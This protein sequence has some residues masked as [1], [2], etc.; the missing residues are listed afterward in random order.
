MNEKDKKQEFVDKITTLRLLYNLRANMQK[1][2]LGQTNPQ[3]CRALI[4]G[5]SLFCQDENLSAKI[6]T[7]IASY[8]ETAPFNPN[9]FKTTTVK[10]DKKQQQNVKKS[11]AQ[12]KAVAL[13]QKQI[14][15]ELAFQHSL[16]KMTDVPENA[17]FESISA[18]DTSFEV[19]IAGRD[20]PLVFNVKIYKG[21]HITALGFRAL[22]DAK[23][24]K[25][26]FDEKTFKLLQSL[27]EKGLKLEKAVE[28]ENLAKKYAPSQYKL[29]LGLKAQDELSAEQKH[30]LEI[31]NKLAATD[32][33]RFILAVKKRKLEASKHQDFFDALAKETDLLK[34][35]TDREKLSALFV[36]NGLND[37]A[38]K[39]QQDF[40]CRQIQ[41]DKKA[42]WNNFVKNAEGSSRFSYYDILMQNVIFEQKKVFQDIYNFSSSQEM[43]EKLASA[44]QKIKKSAT[45]MLPDALCGEILAR[46]IFSSAIN[47]RTNADKLKNM[48]LL[49]NELGLNINFISKKVTRAPD[50]QIETGQQQI[51]IDRQAFEKD[52]KTKISQ[53]QDR[54][55]HKKLHDMGINEPDIASVHHY[56]AVKYNAFV[57]ENL[58]QSKNYVRTA[59]QHPWNFDGHDFTHT[60]DTAGEFLVVDEQQKYS[61]MDFNH[62]RN[63]FNAGA[64]LSLQ[65]P[66]LQVKNAQG[67]YCDLLALSDKPNE[68]GEYISSDK[69]PQSFIHV[70]EYCSSLFAGNKRHND[71]HDL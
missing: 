33:S 22:T 18:H 39:I 4:E 49:L 12:N 20:E 67:R 54:A 57:A 71:G 37:C 14:A 52:K 68:S 1:F 3:I 58:N 69:T 36:K 48:N 31:L 47:Q 5:Y 24:A 6:R 9:A 32:Q 53:E 21:K 30:E 13:L 66:I 38:D 16:G 51:K 25:K 64:N 45:P 26:G 19:K 11:A 46:G 42:V 2:A 34:L 70:P 59:R 8:V 44:Y 23:Y 63:A 29:L 35:M 62:L 27:G 43:R 17:Q 7:L 50:M 61:L 55:F 40:I 65:I 15:E 10:E 56:L 28:A 60:F 41:T